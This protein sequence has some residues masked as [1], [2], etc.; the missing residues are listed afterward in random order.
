[1]HKGDGKCLT[2]FFKPTVDFSLTINLQ[3]I[4]S[5]KKSLLNDGSLGK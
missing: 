1:M 5:N 3:Y 4:S 2:C